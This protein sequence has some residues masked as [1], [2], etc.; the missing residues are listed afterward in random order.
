MWRESTS[1]ARENALTCRPA[2]DDDMQALRPRGPDG[3]RRSRSGSARR[4]ST[5][6][7]PSDARGFVRC[8][9]I[10]VD[11]AM[12]CTPHPATPSRRSS[13]RLSALATAE[14]SRVQPADRFQSR[15]G[16]ALDRGM[17]RDDSSSTCS[18]SPGVFR[19]PWRLR[20]PC[21]PGLPMRRCVGH[22]RQAVIGQPTVWQSARSRAPSPPGLYARIVSVPTWPAF[23]RG[24]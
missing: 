8:G 13:T 24:A 20:P 12:R 1:P 22:R 18:A 23:A 14:L 2:P 7:R 19:G 21:R 10:A 16:D 15:A 6:T 4:S 3:A 11:V 5:I 17:I 9:P